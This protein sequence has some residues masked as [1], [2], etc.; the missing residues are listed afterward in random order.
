M[1]AKILIINICYHDNLHALQ[2]YTKSSFFTLLAGAPSLGKFPYSINVL[3][4]K[5][6][7]FSVTLVWSPYVYSP[8]SWRS[9]LYRHRLR[10]R[11]KSALCASCEVLRAVRENHETKIVR[12]SIKVAHCAK[13]RN[14]EGRQSYFTMVFHPHHGS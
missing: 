6:C 2:R 13:Q 10:S 1:F 9:L 12:S 7:S 11:P 5:R 4:T 14:Q 3:P 8:C